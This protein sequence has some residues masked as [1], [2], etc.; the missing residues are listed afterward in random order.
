MAEEWKA[1]LDPNTN[2][3]YYWNTKTREVSWERPPS[4]SASND[5]ARPAKKLPKSKSNISRRFPGVFDGVSAR[6]LQL[7]TA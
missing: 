5:E 3:H 1:V 2:R 4:L 6:C 7:V